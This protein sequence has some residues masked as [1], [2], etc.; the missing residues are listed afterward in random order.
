MW[1]LGFVLGLPP[2]LSSLTLSGS[3]FDHN[4]A[5]GGA[6]DTGAN[7]GDGWGG[8]L[9]V[10]A[11]TASVSDSTFDKNLALGGDGGVGGN[12]FGGGLFVGTDASVSL[13]GSTIT[14]N[15]ANGGSGSGGG[16]DGEGIG[17]GVYSLG[18]FTFDATTTIKKNHASTSNDDIFP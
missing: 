11:G 13:T 9:S 15:H 17:G 6:S 5:I 10:L 4:Q 2:D 18:T 3:T 7:A 8:G 12:G 16:S 1:A 14:K